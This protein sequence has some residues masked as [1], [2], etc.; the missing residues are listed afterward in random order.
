MKTALRVVLGLCLVALT[1]AVPAAKEWRGLVPLRSNRE[2]VTRVLGPSPDAN[3]TRAR[4]TLKDAFVHIVFATGESYVEECVKRLPPGTVMQ[5]QVRPRGEARLADLGLDGARLKRLDAPGAEGV[6]Y[7]FGEEEG[8][9]VRAQG[10]LVREV[11][12]IA[13]A[14]DR[15]LCPSYY[16]DPGSFVGGVA[17][18]PVAK[19][20]LECPT[21]TP[22]AGERV[23]FTANLSGVDPAL[24]P[25][26]KWQVSG[27]VIVRGRGTG[28][29]TVDTRG[30]AGKTVRATVEVSSPGF[31]EVESCEVRVAPGRKRARCARCP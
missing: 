19:L 18:A 22:R 8:V 10:G 20:A 6:E 30:L 14:A 29:I 21:G 5:I 13:S 11:V 25:A 2:D 17:E 28:S 31:S 12:Y 24:R 9:V 3:R 26:F 15:H 7:Y 1:A 4:Y 27:G 16:E 23:T